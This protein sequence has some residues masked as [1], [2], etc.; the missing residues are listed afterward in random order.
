MEIYWNIMFVPLDTITT[1]YRRK[2]KQ[3]DLKCMYAMNDD[4]Q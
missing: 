2:D 1:F 3:T 4:A